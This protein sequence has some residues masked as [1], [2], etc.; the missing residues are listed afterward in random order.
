M[1]NMADVQGIQIHMLAAAI[2]R[3]GAFQLFKDQP[4]FLSQVGWVFFVRH[5]INL[6]MY[7]II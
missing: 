4:Q 5:L 6:R 2:F 1:W 3:N 7:N